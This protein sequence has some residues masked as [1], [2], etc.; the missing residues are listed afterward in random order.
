[1][2]ITAVVQKIIKREQAGE[3]WSVFCFYGARNA[4]L[5]FAH[6]VEHLKQLALPVVVLDLASVETTQVVADLS[7]SFLGQHKIYWCG[8]IAQLDAATKKFYMQ[9]FQEY[10]GPHSILF[11]S[12]VSPF[13]PIKKTD[14]PEKD[15][16]DELVQANV[17]CELPVL[18]DQ[19][20][21][22]E[23]FGFLYPQESLDKELV[24][25][26]FYNQPKIG[27]D[28]ACIVMHYLSVMGNVS[29]EAILGLL[30]R[31][32]V[33]ERSLFVLS[34]QFFAKDQEAF[35]RLWKEV[36]GDFPLEFWLPYWSE[37]LWQASLFIAQAQELGPVGAKKG[38]TRLPFS[39]MQKDWKKY[40]P[41]E[42]CA[43]HTFLYGID[44]GLKNGYAEHGLELFLAQ[45]L[46]GKFARK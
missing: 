5:F 8:D 29:H 28:Q 39:F 23:I 6:V 3:N 4:P 43:A 17:S 33:P 10:R 37:Q 21:F 27:L 34:Q 22:F 30:Q 9:F 15:R 38:I 14:N 19:Q 11:F 35:F 45:F 41:R 25:T 7:M 32:V 2:S 36:E 24:K 31:V 1:M 20:I 40:G 18:V 13:S 16:K 12:D 44:F 46:Q 42:L 26:F